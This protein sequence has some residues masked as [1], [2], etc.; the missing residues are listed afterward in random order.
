MMVSLFSF[1]KKMRRIYFSVAG[2]GGLVFS[3]SD[4]ACS[5]LLRRERSMRAILSLVG[6]CL[7]IGVFL[8]TGFCWVR[9]Q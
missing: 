5:C 7:F 9:G 2:G 6:C 4:D 8:Y 1:F 3:T